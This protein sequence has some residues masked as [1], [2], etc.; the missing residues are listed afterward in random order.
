MIRCT[1]HGLSVWGP[2][3]SGWAASEAVLAGTVPWSEAECAVPA[4]ALLSPTERRRAGATT[5]L[6][7]AAASEATEAEPDRAALETVF[8][9]ANGDGAVVGALMEALQGEEV[10]LSP[11]QF[12]NSVHNAAAGYWHIA[13]GS[14]RPSL[15]L[16]GHDAA[17]GAGLL[18]AAAT[19]LVRGGPVLLCAY[20]VPMPAPLHGARPTA[21]PFAAALVL[22]PAEA[23][24][25]RAV[26]E[27][28]PRPGTVPE[29]V[30][31]DALAALETGNP[32]ARALPLLRA[33]AAR[34]EASL[35][36]AA[37]PESHLE[38]RCLPC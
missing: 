21:F 5:R 8:S 17:F 15:S 14:T 26:L 23:P 29:A 20:D 35:R 34:R 32:A 12:H 19:A 13:V 25:A 6:A 1:V 4:P 33:L 27:L 38:L 11:T 3:L 31:A 2:G 30:P 22:R 18:A 24:G 28:D 9:S 7:L 10:A 36:L 37:G 16:G